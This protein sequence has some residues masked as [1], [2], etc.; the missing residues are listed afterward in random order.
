[1]E[2]QLKSIYVGNIPFKASEE[3][4]KDLFGQ[5]GEVSSVKLVTDRETGKKRGFGF[6]EMSDDQ[7]AQKAIEALEGYEFLGRTLKVNEAKPRPERPAFR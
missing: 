4:L 2:S 1:M 5:H 6:V 3:E 7:E